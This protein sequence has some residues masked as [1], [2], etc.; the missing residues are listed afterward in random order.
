MTNVHLP[1]SLSSHCSRTYW[2]LLDRVLNKAKVPIIPL[3]LEN[4]VFVL[5]FKAKAQISNYYFIHQCAIIGTIDTSNQVPNITVSNVPKLTSIDI[6]H[7][8]ITKIIQSLNPNKAHGFDETSVHM[9]KISDDALVLPLKIIFE[10]CI[11]NG[12]F[13]SG[14]NLLCPQEKQQK[15]EAKPSV[16]LSQFSGKFLRR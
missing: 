3:L 13:P 10:N 14:R 1:V 7:K 8:K 15:H 9:M 11:Q 6:S 16:I 2:L 12:I 5:D 4:D